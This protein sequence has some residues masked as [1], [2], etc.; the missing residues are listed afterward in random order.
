M[1]Y[2]VVLS[3]LPSR[4]SAGD[5]LSWRWSDHRFP[6]SDWTL[7]YVLLKAG[8]KIAIDAVADGTDHLVELPNS[9]TADYES[10]EYRWK[11]H[12]S[13]DD[14]E[15]YEVD[16]GS[17]EITEDYASQTR[18]MDA[19]SHVKKV[20]DALEASI[21]GRAS[22]TQMQQTVGGVQVQH[23]ELA[24]QIKLRDRY[25]IRYRKELAASGKGSSRRTIKPR[26]DNN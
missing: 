16:S 11:A 20:L 8:K 23:I 24:D 1:T 14:G 26:F 7:Q 3:S 9:T 2:S 4:F 18:G 5:S 25:A 17:V 22:K 15:R 10:G 13:N 6:A 19:R 21:E 12:V